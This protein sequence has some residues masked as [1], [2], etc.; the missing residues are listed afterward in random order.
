MSE[1]QVAAWI[2][3]GLTAL[4][5]SGLFLRRSRLAFAGAGSRHHRLQQATIVATAIAV[6]VL[7]GLGAFLIVSGLGR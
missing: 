6:G 5:V 3:A 2:A 4:V 1:R 7:M